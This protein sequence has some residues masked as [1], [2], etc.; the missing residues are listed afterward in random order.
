M[1]RILFFLSIFS[2]GTFLNAQTVFQKAIS[3]PFSANPYFDIS[4][5]SPCSDGGYIFSISSNYSEAGLMKTDANG[6]VLWSKKFISDS[7]YVSPVS[8]CVGECTGGGYYFLGGDYE[9]NYNFD[10]FFIKMDAS[11]NTIWTKEFQANLA[12]EGTPSVFQEPNGDFLISTP[13]MV[14]GV[15]RLSSTGNVIYQKRFG[16]DPNNS[17]KVPPAGAAMGT[18]GGMLITSYMTGLGLVKTDASGNIQWT[19]DY[20]DNS[21]SSNYYPGGVVATSDGGFVISGIDFMNNDMFLIKVDASGTIIWRKLFSSVMQPEPTGLTQAPNGNLQVTGTDYYSGHGFAMQFDASGNFLS[22]GTIGDPNMQD[23]FFT[24]LAIH[25]CS[26]NGMIV[27]GL[28][29]NMTTSTMAT[30]IFKTD[31]SGNLGCEYHP[32]ILTDVSGSF[33]LPVDAQTTV[34]QT[35]VT[36]VAN[37]QP[38]YAITSSPIE[39]DFCLLFSVNE[40]PENGISLSAYPSPLASGE[41]LHLNVSGIE[42]TSVISIFDANGK[43]VKQ[44]NQELPGN[45]NTTLEISTGDLSAGIYLVR[46]TGTDQQVLGMTKFIVR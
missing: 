2:A 5:I 15:T 28:C 25:S 1:K 10:N 11:G 37:Q 32:V 8:Y 31:A 14:M 22:G 46:I 34:Y 23:I 7:A 13:G 6:A 44:L 16:V 9:S 39:T 3:I 20:N 26:D 29:E 30:S 24:S 19:K 18:D 45:Q 17:T 41:N 43:V 40:Q 21:F 4:S 36:A 42:G 12:M 33:A 35:N 38:I 27:G